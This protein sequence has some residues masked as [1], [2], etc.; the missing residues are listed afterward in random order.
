[1]GIAFG[2][3]EL[4]GGLGESSN[5][6]KEAQAGAKTVCTVNSS[7]A[8]SDVSAVQL[9]PC[10]VTDSSGLTYSDRANRQYLLMGAFGGVGLVLARVGTGLVVS[11]FGPSP[12][13]SKS[14][15]VVPIVSPK[16]FGA[17]LTARF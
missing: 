16:L 13:S 15:T 6:S 9:Q 17:G 7:G 12:P 5:Y 14:V 2:I 3:V 4:V 10:H 11:S 8:V 1:M